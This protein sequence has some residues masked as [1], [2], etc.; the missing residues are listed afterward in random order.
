MPVTKDLKG[1]IEREEGY[2]WEGWGE[3]GKGR[4]EGK[5]VAYNFV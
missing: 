3:Y 5:L 4:C 2:K 1:L